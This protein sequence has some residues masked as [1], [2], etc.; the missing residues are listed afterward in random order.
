MQ[1]VMVERLET[2]SGERYQVRAVVRALDLL[3]CF[4]PREPELS[5]VQLAERSGLSLSTVFRLL[6]TLEGRG[7]V[8]HDLDTGRYRLGLSCLRLS[9]TVIAQMDLRERLYPLL[10]ELREECC[11]TVHL[12]V[13]DSQRME[14]VYLDK[15]D[16]LLPIGIMSSHIGGRAPAHCTGVGKVL[17]A[18]ADP[19]KV[20]AFYRQ[21]P[22][23][24]FT[25]HTITDLDALLT[26]LEDVRRLG[27]ALD[28]VEHETDVKCIAVPVWSHTGAAVASVSVSGP[29]AR[30]DGY[31]GQ[32]KLAARMIALG[33]DASQRLGY[34]G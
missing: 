16:G 34:G 30:M 29:R 31:L 17:L 6:Q 20:L 33:A 11:E 19:A 7:Y 4:T 18:F 23:Q 5:L 14:V 24:R 12:A 10:A 2:S 32:G 21:H 1:R 15:L 28:D 26:C 3:G 9:E 25:P 8:E 27:Y 13:L 22:P